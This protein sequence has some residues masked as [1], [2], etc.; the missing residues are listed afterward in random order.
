MRECERERS[1]TGHIRC[2]DLRT[3]HEKQFRGG[4]V[5]K[6]HKWL[7]HPTLGSRVIKKREAPPARGCGGTGRAG[8]KVESQFPLK[9]VN[10]SFII[11]DVKNKSTGLFG[12]RLFAKRI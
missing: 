9:S 6:T 10:L 4:L 5:F 12:N 8:T 11:T 7:Y 2:D 1:S 3:T